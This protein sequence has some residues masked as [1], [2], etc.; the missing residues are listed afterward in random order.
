MINHNLLSHFQNINTWKSKGI[1]A[2]HKPLLM[3]LALGE[4]QRGN[5]GFIPYTRIEP[6]LK[7]LLLDFGPH[8]KT[9]YPNFPFTKLANDK[10]WQFNKPELLDTRQDYSS[11]FL[12]DHDLQGKFPDE[13]TQQLKQNPELLRSVAEQLLE[14][15]FPD[16]LHQDILDAVGLNIEI[17]RGN[18]QQKQVKKRDPLFRESILKAYE[19]Q[20]AV[21]GFGVW[22]K[23]KILALE[24]AHIMWHQAGGPDVEVNGLALC[25]THHKLFDLGAFTLNEDLRMLVSDEVNGIGANEWLLQYHGK[26]IRPPQKKSFYPNPAFTFWHVNEVFKGGYRDL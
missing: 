4:I 18:S 6:K 12:R 21:C 19:Y 10:L 22:L 5:T 3:L 17:S 20:C 2:P 1:R 26:S 15:N 23:H 8:R 9:L 16:T 14:Q 13:V 11:K 24:A 7:E 25:A